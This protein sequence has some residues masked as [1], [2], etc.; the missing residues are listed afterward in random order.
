MILLSTILNKSRWLIGI[1]KRLIPEGD[2]GHGFQSCYSCDAVFTLDKIADVSF[3]ITSKDLALK[4][5]QFRT[6]YLDAAA[7]AIAEKIN[8]DGLSLYEDIQSKVHHVCEK[9]DNTFFL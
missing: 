4:M 1:F 8:Q 2:R 6:K 7:V 9:S 5:P 3:E